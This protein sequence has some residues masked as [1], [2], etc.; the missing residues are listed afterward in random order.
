[1][2]AQRGIASQRLRVGLDAASAGN[3]IAQGNHGAPLGK[4]GAHLKVPLETDTQS[5]Q[6]LGDLLSWVTCQVPGT[7][8]NFDAGNDSRI[9][10]DFDQGSAIFLLLADRLV[11]EDRPTDAFAEAGRGHDQLA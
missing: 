1:F 8:I 3:A 11:V 9:D 2:L 6:T 4:T 10:E 5:V 7:D